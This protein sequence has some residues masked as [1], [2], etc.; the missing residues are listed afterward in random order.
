MI[1]HTADYDRLAFEIC[2]NAPDVPM[3]FL[4]SCTVAEEWDAVFRRENDVDE[5]LCE[6]LGHRA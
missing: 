5:N 2:E 1:L 3:E 6:R 4:S